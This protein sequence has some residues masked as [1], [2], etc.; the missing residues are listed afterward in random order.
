M[1]FQPISPFGAVSRTTI[2]L[3]PHAFSRLFRLF[4]SDFSPCRQLKLRNSISDVQIVTVVIAMFSFLLVT[5][6][7]LPIL[8]VSASS[9]PRSLKKHLLPSIHADVVQGVSPTSLQHHMRRP[10]SQ[11]HRTAFVQ[12]NVFLHQLGSW[13]FPGP[14]WLLPQH[15]QQKR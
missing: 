8:G 12:T 10:Q 3:Q 2:Y 9:Q 13:S 14:R 4:Y 5:V 1:T 6:F 11:V 7:A 15:I